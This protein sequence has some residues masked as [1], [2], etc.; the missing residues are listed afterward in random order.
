MTDIIEMADTWDGVTAEEVARLLGIT[1]SWAA[2]HYLRPA[3]KRG[4]MERRKQ[5][6]VFIY[7]P[8]AA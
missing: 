1:P 3:V 7:R 5:G 4:Q 6:G 8:V 2:A